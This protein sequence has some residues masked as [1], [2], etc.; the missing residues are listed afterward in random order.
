MHHCLRFR[1][2]VMPLKQ[3]SINLPMPLI[4]KLN[5]LRK[6]GYTMVGYILGL[7]ERELVDVPETTS[8]TLRPKLSRSGGGKREGKGGLL[9]KGTH[10]GQTK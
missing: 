5:T 2:Q 4:R 1:R 9:R 7:L 10:H 3:I 8:P 6:R